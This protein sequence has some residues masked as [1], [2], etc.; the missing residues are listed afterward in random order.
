MPR[1]RIAESKVICILH[2]D[3]YYKI[4]SHRGF[5]LKKGLNSW[6]QVG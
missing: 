6:S 4:A 1:T 2:S 3:R 5:Y